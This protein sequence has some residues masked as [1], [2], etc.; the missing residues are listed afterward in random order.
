[1]KNVADELASLR[2]DPEQKLP[3]GPRFSRRTRVGAAV[4][5]V[6]AALVLLVIAFRPPAVE[7]AR[8]TSI[9]S[10]QAATVL[11]AGGYAVAH[12]KIQLGSKITG[13]VVWI[14]V[15]KGDRVQKDQV[16]V[17]LEDREFR[18]QVDQA[19]GAL[20]SARARLQQLQNGSRPEEVEHAKARLTE[21]EAGLRLARLNLERQQG[22][23]RDG[24][25]AR[26]SL[27]DAS[28]QHDAA[29]AQVEAAQKNYELVRK[30]PRAEEIQQARAQMEQAAGALQFAQTQLDATQIRAP[31]SG[32]ILE[33]LVETGEMVTTM[34]VGERGAKSSVVSLADLSDLQVELDISQNDFARVFMGQPCSITPDAFPD[35]RYRG[36]VAEI[37]PEANR[38]KATVQVKVKVENPD[39]FLRPE[40]NARVAFEDP[41]A[42]QVASREL[43]V[44]RSAVFPADG[45]SIVVVVENGRAVRKSVILGSET[46]GTVR[47]TSGLSGNE[48]VVVREPGALKDGQRVRLI[49]N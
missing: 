45:R 37:A 30:G 38:Q 41:K 25:V 10:K 1:M 22:L 43:A 19:R 18:A 49:N 20:D 4:V 6:A 3:P 42:G 35:R 31:I 40:M 17:R 9:E 8:V 14:G 28:S 7:V 46:A 32:T 44:P 29:R 39:E 47:V 5:A 13:R 36:T 11:V 24:V 2:I 34:F 33:R 27:D 15:E 16:L 48:M 21:A 12:H 26:Q 23:A